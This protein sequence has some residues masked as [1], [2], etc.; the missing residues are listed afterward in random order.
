MKLRVLCLH[1]YR[2]NEK[3]FREKTGGLRKLLKKNI[4]FIFAS[5]P[6][7]IPEAGN[8]E[9]KDEEQER[10]WWFSRRE[11]GYNALD[12][13]DIILGYQNSLDFVTEK[14]ANEG[15][16]D[17]ILGFS[18]GG[19]FASL[20]SALKDQPDNAID[21]EFVIIIAGFQSQ[22]TPHASMYHSPLCCPSFHTIGVSDAV[23]PS[24][25]SEE[26]AATFKNATV[27]RHDGGHYIPA[28]PTLRTAITEFLEPFISET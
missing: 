7:I 28:S 17:G 26:L 13:T 24:A 22:L 21:F 14:I 8:L 4:D 27:Y 2:Q 11:K 5:A 12:R 20:L 18:Q 25:A 1:G 6:H 9:R 23:I 3:S 19:C 15:P 16:F 10:G